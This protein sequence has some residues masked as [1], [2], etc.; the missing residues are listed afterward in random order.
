MTEYDTKATYKSFLV[1]AYL[2]YRVLNDV[3]VFTSDTDS[4]P[5][6][7][8]WNGILNDYLTERE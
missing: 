8:Q 5:I 1:Y 7:S 4:I 2:K 3:V 6:T